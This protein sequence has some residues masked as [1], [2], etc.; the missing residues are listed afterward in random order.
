MLF[1]KAGTI[2]CSFGVAQYAAGDSASTLIARA[3]RALY[4]AK[5]NGRDRVELT[6][7]PDPAINDIA[8][9]A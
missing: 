8:S 9:V 7:L 3:D 4:R 1:D 5:L 2:T 6:P